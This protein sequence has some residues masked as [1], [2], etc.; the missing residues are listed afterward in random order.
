[1]GTVDNDSEEIPEEAWPRSW[2]QPVV[3]GAPRL[4]EDAFRWSAASQVG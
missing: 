4:D 1:V 3:T 2:W